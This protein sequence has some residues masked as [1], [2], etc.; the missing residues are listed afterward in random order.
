MAADLNRNSRRRPARWAIAHLFR[1]RIT[2]LLLL[3]SGKHY[4]DAI[5]AQ[6][7]NAF[8]SHCS[9]M[10]ADAD[11]YAARRRTQWHRGRRL[12][13]SIFAFSPEHSAARFLYFI[14]VQS[15]HKV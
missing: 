8:I 2:L 4:F 15:L 13:L 10:P 12:I 14:R 1:Q 7:G 11:L 3:S 9:L 6:L 5:C